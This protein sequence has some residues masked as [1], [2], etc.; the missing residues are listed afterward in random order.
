MNTA[1][2]SYINSLG[3]GEDVIV[4]EIRARIIRIQGITDVAISRLT[5]GAITATTN[6]AN[7]A[8]ADNEIARIKVSDITLG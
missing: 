3:V 7:I 5:G 1:V 6:I 8:I 2:T 4:E